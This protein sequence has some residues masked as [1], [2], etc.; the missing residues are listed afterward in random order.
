MLAS[1][2]PIDLAAADL[3]RYAARNHGDVMTENAPAR[4]VIDIERLPSQFPTHRHQASFWESLGR[5]VATFGFLEEILGK[6]IFAFTATRPLDATH[7]QEAYSEWLLTLERALTD[8]LGN[9]IDTYAKAMRE[10]GSASIANINDLIRELRRAAEMR[11]ILCHASWGV[12]TAAGASIPFFVNRQKRVVDTAMD[13]TFIDQVQR[14][15]ADLACTVM[16]SVTHLG[17]QFPGSAG[18]GKP[19]WEPQPS[20]KLA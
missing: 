19:I 6:A 2:A 13:M 16:N 7:A 11:N 12:P 1:L 5:A 20:N 3:W 9:L 18:P 4:S 17:W 15:A 14:H 10:H 8:P